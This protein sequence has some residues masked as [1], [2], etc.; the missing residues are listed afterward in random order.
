MSAVERL[1]TY[2]EHQIESQF[3][4]L[5]VRN[6]AIEYIEVHQQLLNALKSRDIDAVCQLMEDHFAQIIKTVKQERA[7]KSSAME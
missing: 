4:S 3:E 7:D 5:S 6:H 2:E 1:L